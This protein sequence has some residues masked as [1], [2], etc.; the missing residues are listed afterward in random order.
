MTALETAAPPKRVVRRSRKAV[1]RSAFGDRSRLALLGLVL[2]A[3]GTLAALL[4]AGVFGSGR[5]D[6]P[7][8]DPMIVEALRAQPLL[9]RWV[10]IGVGVVLVVVGL[11]WAARSLRPERRPDLLLET[12]QDTTLLVTATAAAEAV[13]DRAAELPGVSRARGRMVGRDDDPALRLTVWLTDEADVVAVCRALD[14]EIVTEAREALGVA[15]L[16]VAVRLE[17]DSATHRPRVA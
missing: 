8:L 1:A 11:V 2:L 13:A 3:A 15:H 9:W 4:G 12:A 14:E 7:L 5:A 16:P 17:L 10:A 6:R